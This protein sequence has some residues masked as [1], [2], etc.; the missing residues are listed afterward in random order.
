MNQKELETIN[1]LVSSNNSFCNALKEKKTIR[2]DIY[3]Q[4]ELI[5]LY[6]KINYQYISKL[7]NIEQEIIYDLISNNN[8]T[9]EE[10][11]LIYKEEKY[12]LNFFKNLMNTIEK[13]KQSISQ[14]KVI[15]F[16]PPI[17]EN[18]SHPVKSKKSKIVDITFLNHAIFLDMKDRSHL[19]EEGLEITTETQPYI[20]ENNANFREL[21]NTLILALL[22]PTPFEYSYGYLEILSSY[23]CLY[24]IIS[25]AKNKFII[26]LSDIRIPKEKIGLKKCEYQDKYL[27]E[28]SSEISELNSKRMRLIL[29]KNA[30]SKSLQNYETKLGRIN[31]HID[32]IEKKQIDCYYNQ[33]AYR[34]LDEIYNP[35][36]LKYLFNSYE[37]CNVS[38]DEI[39]ENP[40]IRFFH[41]SNDEID[42]YCAMRLDTLLEFRNYSSVIPKLEYP[43]SLKLT[44]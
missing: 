38:I 12:S 17:K 25:Y 29:S 27:D 22:K 41:L 20:E 5:L 3:I 14:N 26:P 2:I 28:L 23:L 6:F 10:N 19:L 36:F 39:F 16:I 35:T 37:Q 1:H 40:V 31:S 43:N 24:P 34:N 44:I 13:E 9:I 33:F 42:F 32:A 30:L 18:I 11:Y 15:Q 8:F 21:L 4:I 7:N